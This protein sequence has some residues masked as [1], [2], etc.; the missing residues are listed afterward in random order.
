MC[1]TTPSTA[2]PATSVPIAEA[3]KLLRLVAP[4]AL[5]EKLYGGA[6]KICESVIEIRTSHEMQVVNSSVAQHT[7]GEDSMPKGRIRVRQR[8]PG[9][10][11]HYKE[12]IPQEA[13][14]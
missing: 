9:H 8:R 2:G 1:L 7:M 10:S 3:T 13:M 12:E 4:T 11:S 6:E 5:T 14:F